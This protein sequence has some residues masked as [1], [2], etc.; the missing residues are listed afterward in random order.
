MNQEAHGQ[1]TAFEIDL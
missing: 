1:L